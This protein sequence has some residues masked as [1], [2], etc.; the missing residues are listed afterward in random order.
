MRASHKLLTQNLISKKKD[1]FLYF[2]K[3]NRKIKKSLLNIFNK[4][5][6]NTA[7]GVAPGR[8]KG[9]LSWA[10]LAQCN[11]PAI[12]YCLSSV[13][14]WFWNCVSALKMVQYIKRSALKVLAG[15]SENRNL[16]Q[17]KW[18]RQDAIE[19]RGDPG[20]KSLLASGYCGSLGWSQTQNNMN[21][22]WAAGRKPSKHRETLLFWK[23]PRKNGV[24]PCRS[25]AEGSWSL[26]PFKACTL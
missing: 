8:K 7:Q 1:F 18:F 4:I 19:I 24:R 16:P 9:H 14:V 21:Y 10:H 22:P 15:R 11:V 2:L 12:S 23:Q 6:K 13:F 3:Y 17:G 25:T 26:N 5:N 20:A